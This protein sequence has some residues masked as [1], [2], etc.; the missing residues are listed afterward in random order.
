MDIPLH[1][2]LV[3]G[4]AATAALLLLTRAATT[5]RDS[6]EMLALYQDTLADSRVRRLELREADA[7]EASDDDDDDDAGDEA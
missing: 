4:A 3:L 7:A 6:G 2:L 1:P 5:L